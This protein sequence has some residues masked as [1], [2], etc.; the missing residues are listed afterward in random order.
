MEQEITIRRLNSKDLDEFYPLFEKMISHD[1]PEIASKADFFLKS[2]YSKGR[3]HSSLVFPKIAIFGAFV[4]DERSGSE[5]LVG[6]IWGNSTYAGL[7]FISWLKVAGEYKRNGIG[8]RLIGYYEDFVRSKGG[9]V[10]EL[11]CF[12]G[13]KEYYRKQGYEVI[14]IRE[15]G[16]FKLK[17]FILN[18]Y[19]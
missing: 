8:G 13:M 5:K 11:Y 3:I 9:H 10:V 12:Q 19:L 7:G 6:F 2:D 14:G 1:I 16:Y 15:K 4:K 17:Q 18:K